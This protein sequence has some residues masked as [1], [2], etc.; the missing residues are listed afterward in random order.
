MQQGNWKGQ[1]L[2]REG[3][4]WLSSPEK[5]GFIWEVGGGGGWIE[6]FTVLSVMTHVFVDYK[7][8]L[9]DK[10]YDSLYVR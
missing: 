3:A 5:R 10:P 4:Y 9:E 2:P 8:I 1:H 6:K 7:D